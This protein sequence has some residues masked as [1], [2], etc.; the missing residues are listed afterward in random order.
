M[1]REVDRFEAIGDGGY[2]TTVVVNQEFHEVNTFG[3]VRPPIA[4]L[5][6]FRTTDGYHCSEIS[7]DEYQIVNDPFLPEMIVRRLR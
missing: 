5:R 4:G 7:G 6:E 3:G 1:Q 2:Q